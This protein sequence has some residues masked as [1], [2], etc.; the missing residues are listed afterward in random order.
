MGLGEPIYP[1]PVTKEQIA[2]NM[3]GELVIISVETELTT[4]FNLDDLK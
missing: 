4:D 3:R 2:A 1:N